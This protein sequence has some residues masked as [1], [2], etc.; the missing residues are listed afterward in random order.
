MTRSIAPYMPFEIAYFEEFQSENEAICR[1]RYFKSSA[2]RRY[3][4][5]KLS[6]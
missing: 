4:K 3:L 1:E 2:G 5:K 6:S